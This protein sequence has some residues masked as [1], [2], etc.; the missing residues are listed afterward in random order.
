MLIMFAT[1]GSIAPAVLLGCL[2]VSIGVV[3]SRIPS[4]MP[5]FLSFV[6]WQRGSKVSGNRGYVKYENGNKIKTSTSRTN[7]FNRFMSLRDL[8]TLPEGLDLFTIKDDAVKDDHDL[9]LVAARE[10]PGE[11][12]VTNQ[13]L[14]SDDVPKSMETDSEDYKPWDVHAPPTAHLR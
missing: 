10:Q 12:L 14:V 13:I 7:R 9:K 1:T 8:D 2:E 6:G 11:I 5:L 3:S 4:L